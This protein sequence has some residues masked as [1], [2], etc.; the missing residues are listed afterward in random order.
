VASYT[1]DEAGDTHGTLIGLRILGRAPNV[2]DTEKNAAGSSVAPSQNGDTEKSAPGSPVETEG[3]VT[4]VNCAGT[5]MLLTLTLGSRQIKLHAS[6]FAQLTY[7][8]DNSGP[9]NKGFLPCTEL[10]GRNVAVVYATVE[11][12]QYGGDI[13]S[14]E[15][16]K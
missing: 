14:I 8:D 4:D 11:Q 6:N 12:S 5:E 10:K 1:P 7:Y 15:V 3:K 2:A 13:Q 9:S 16:E